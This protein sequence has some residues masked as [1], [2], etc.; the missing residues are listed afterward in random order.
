[1]SEKTELIDV[2]KGTRCPPP[3]EFQGQPVHS[4]QT[5]CGSNSYQGWA[6]VDGVGT[7]DGT[8]IITAGPDSSARIW[9]RASA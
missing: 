6:A 4:G 1:V 5:A 3:T 7:L 2:E 9:D 8:Q